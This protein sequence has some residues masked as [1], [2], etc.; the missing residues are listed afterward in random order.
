MTDTILR[1]EE[2]RLG[3]GN[4][5]DG[6]LVVLNGLTLELRR[7]EFLSVVGPSGC[8]KTTFLHVLNGLLTPNSG[9]VEYS[10]ASMALVF[11]RPRLLPWR[12]VLDNAIFG[13]ECAG[14]EPGGARE[15]ASALLRTMGLDGFLQAYPHQLSEG[16][17]QRVNLARAILVDPDI[18]LMDEPFS[19]LDVMTR[20]A[21]QND[22]LA[23]WKERGLSVVFVT[24]SIEEAVYL[25]DRVMFLTDKPAKIRDV[26]PV[27]L[28]RP[29]GEGA[30][31]RLDLFARAESF[32][33]LLRPETT[34]S[35]E[36]DGTSLSGG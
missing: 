6:D 31:G 1:V 36:G 11:Q 30:K 9:R 18:L 4:G 10:K 23:L 7:G 16:M 32:A 22:L 28:P 12:T 13:M 19:A 26:L 2:I 34:S 20:R 33:E 17:K 3:F 27:D 8:G 5:P 21:L 14:K 29:R 15:K 25:S 35:S 24:H